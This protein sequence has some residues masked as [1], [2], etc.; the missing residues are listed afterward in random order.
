MTCVK[1]LTPALGPCVYQPSLRASFSSGGVFPWLVQGTSTLHCQ[2]QG[3]LFPA[4][5]RTGLQVMDEFGT[6]RSDN[7]SKARDTAAQ[8]RVPVEDGSHGA[9][10]DGPTDTSTPEGGRGRGRGRGGK[11]TNSI[12]DPCCNWMA[13]KPGSP[14]WTSL[15]A[16]QSQPSFSWRVCMSHGWPMTAICIGWADE[17]WCPRW[18]LES[19]E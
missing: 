12:N 6:F 7:F 1:L 14:T 10:G 18:C 4:S 13:Q 5:E 19:S 17:I 2:L 16:S 15:L 9:L 11:T 8:A 3:L